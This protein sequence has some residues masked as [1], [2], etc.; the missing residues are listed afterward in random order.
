MLTKNTLCEECLLKQSKM[1]CCDF[2]NVKKCSKCKKDCSTRIHENYCFSCSGNFGI[3]R[4][5]GN[6]TFDKKNGDV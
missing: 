6:S 5:C 2:R 3:C 4:D 1:Y